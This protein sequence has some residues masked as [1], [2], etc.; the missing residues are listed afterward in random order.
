MGVCM[1]T[2][3]AAPTTAEESFYNLKAADI[4]NNEVDFATLK[5]KV[6][7]VMS[8][9]VC[10]T[11]RRVPGTALMYKSPCIVSMHRAQS[12]H[13]VKTPYKHPTSTTPHRTIPGGARGQCSISLRPDQQQLCRN[14]YV[15]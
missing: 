1:S 10:N 3:N 6:R 12:N 14:A 15:V 13:P 8:G 7:Q 9:S 11:Y 4:D 5:D 2:A